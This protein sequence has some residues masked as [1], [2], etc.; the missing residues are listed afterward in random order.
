MTRVPASVRLVACACACVSACAH[1]GGPAG[2]AAGGSDS[3]ALHSLFAAYYE[4]ALA[5][6]PV[7]A[8]TLGDHRYDAHLA[9]D[10]SE[11]YRRRQKEVYTRLLSRVE[12]LSAGRFTDDERLSLSLLRSELGMRLEGLAYPEHLLPMS[13]VSG[14]PVDFPVMGSGAGVHRFETTVD[15]DN[16]LGRITDFV[17]WVD[18]AIE[19]MRRGIAAGVVHPAIIIDTLLPQLDAQIVSDPETSVFFQP[20]RAF[21]VKVPQTERLRLLTA[22]RAAIQQ[23]IVPAYRR[24]RAFLADEY[25]PHCRRDP[26]FEALPNGVAWYAYRVRAATTTRLTPDQIFEL[27][28]SEVARIEREMLALRDAASWKG[29]LASF[30]RSLAEGPGRQTTRAALLSAYQ[31]LSEQVSRGLPALFGRLPRAPFEIRP[32]EAFR[33]DAAPSQYQPPSPDGDRPGIF[34]VNTADVS[35]GRPMRASATLFLHE[36]LPGH[37]LQIALQY[38]NLAL[39]RFHQTISYSAY[40]EG[41]ALY[42]ETLGQALGVYADPAQALEHLGEEMLRAVRLVV[43]TGLHHRGWT[44]DR[45]IAYFHAHVVST[46]EDVAADSVREVNRYLAWPGQAL[47]YK[48]GQLQIAELRQRAASEMAFFDLRAFHD[49]VLR[50]GPLP[51]DLLA[52]HMDQWI[53]ARRPTPEVPLDAPRP[54][55]R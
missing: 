6:D 51:L 10:I 25:R 44:R 42:A 46:G 53:A 14:W 13:Q 12:V 50:N 47:A 19:N 36:V 24:L 22:Y 30:A 41:W 54:E 40:E 27:G 7:L 32:I 23:Q 33:E 8:T 21:P 18:T 55:T 43:D 26:A 35:K 31:T 20:V 37:H 15:Y 39:P 38:E 9:I 2:S 16:F 45:A 52:A 1:T 17:T 3:G 5:L 29:D 28:E 49:E 48:I 34:F 11:G 4:A